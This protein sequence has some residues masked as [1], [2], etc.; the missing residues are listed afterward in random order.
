MIYLGSLSDYWV[1]LEYLPKAAESLL[2]YSKAEV[3]KTQIWDGNDGVERKG[4]GRGT[5]SNRID[6]LRNGSELWKMSIG[7]GNC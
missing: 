7:A 1:R 3:V 5:W 4:L 6:L 2:I